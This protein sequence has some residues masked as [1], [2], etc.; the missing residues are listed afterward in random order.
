MPVLVGVAVREGV[1]VLVGVRV[2]VE[3]R[4]GVDVLEGVKDVNVIVAVA[5]MG[6]FDEVEVYVGVTGLVAVMLWV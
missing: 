1:G 6:V 3:V 2:A 5:E 4:D